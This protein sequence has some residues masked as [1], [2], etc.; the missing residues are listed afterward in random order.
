MI[1]GLVD[2]CG[3]RLHQDGIDRFNGSLDLS[4][5]Y[6][7]RVQVDARGGGIGE[8]KWGAFAYVSDSSRN[9]THDLVRT[10]R[11]YETAEGAASDLTFL[12]LGALAT[13]ALVIART[14]KGELGLA[15]VQAPQFAAEWRAK[16][17][18]RNA[19]TRSSGDP[20]PVFE[21]ETKR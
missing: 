20:L 14:G 3:V 9:E 21:M 7:L 11:N 19:A 4:P 6:S 10:E 17:E 15:L 1:G 12:V 16:L 2:V 18:A 8:G 13:V 5:P